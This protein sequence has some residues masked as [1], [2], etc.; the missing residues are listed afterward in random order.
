VNMKTARELGITIPHEVA[1][2][3]TEVVDG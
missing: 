3:I 2:Q 1:L